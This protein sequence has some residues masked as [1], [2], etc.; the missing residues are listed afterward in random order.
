MLIKPQKI[1]L[2]GQSWTGIGNGIQWNYHVFNML[3][4]NMIVDI[5]FIGIEVILRSGVKKKNATGAGITFNCAHFIDGIKGELVGVFE[6]KF[7][8][9]KGDAQ[10]KK[11]R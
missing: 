3:L 2:F 1:S 5:E 6:K 8:E 4:A 9:E 7:I 11:C 10:R